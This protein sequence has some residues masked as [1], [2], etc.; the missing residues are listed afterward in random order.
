MQLFQKSSKKLICKSNSFGFAF[1][2]F[3]ITIGGLTLL[4]L[5]FL[6]LIECVKDEVCR[7][8]IIS[9]HSTNIMQYLFGI[10]IGVLMIILGFFPFL[11]ISIKRVVFDVDRNRLEVERYWIL[12]RNLDKR[13]YPLSN[14]CDVTVDIL[15]QNDVPDTY[16]AVVFL[17]N[18]TSVH[19][20]LSYTGNKK[21]HQKTVDRIKG[22]LALH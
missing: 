20:S 19:L 18:G 10:L 1:A 12:S 21:F 14:I 2:G 3:V 15:K 4:L 8:A 6:N 7:K 22:F 5:L 9:F 13:H 16:Q 17:N 11:N